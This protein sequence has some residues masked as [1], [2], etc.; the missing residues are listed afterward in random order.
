[1]RDSSFLLRSCLFNILLAA[2]ID[3]SPAVAQDSTAAEKLVRQLGSKSFA[4]REAAEPKLLALGHEAVDAVRAGTRSDDA[5]VVRRCERLLPKIRA[6]IHDGLISGKM[7]LPGKAGTTFKEI[8][9]NSAESRT[10]FATMVQDD[11]RAEIAEL[12]ASDQRRAASLYAAEVARVKADPKKVA[13][14]DAVL[15]IFVGVCAGPKAVG[16]PFDAYQ[17]IQVSIIDLAVGP[18]GQSFVKLFNAWWK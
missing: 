3:A 15:V 17:A 2:A 16:D 9:G 7:A 11:R 10:L 8:V 14:G 6:A 13:P 4:E 18:N 5:E 1:M 12:A